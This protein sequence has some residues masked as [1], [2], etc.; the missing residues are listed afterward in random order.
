M[1]ASASSSLQ[2]GWYARVRWIKAVSPC[3][4]FP[5]V[6]FGVEGYLGIC[7]GALAYALKEGLSRIDVFM[8]RLG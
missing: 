5:E 7:T 1:S 2:R 6:F 8:G 3:P 4:S